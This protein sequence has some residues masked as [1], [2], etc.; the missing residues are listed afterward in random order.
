MIIF[1]LAQCFKKINV[2]NIYPTDSLGN[3][4]GNSPNDNQWKNTEYKSSELDLFN[5]LDTANLSGT[6]LPVISNSY[7]G[8]PNPF[9]NQIRVS[10]FLTQPLNGEIILKYVVANEHMKS[11]Q[12]GCVR[13]YITSSINFTIQGNFK[14]GN[15]RLYFTYS[16]Q[17]H[18]HFFKTWGNI[19]KV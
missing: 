13:L 2:S 12:K 18:E 9:T 7:Y 6:L 10:T 19:K 4:M 5:E 3:L 16:S 15:Y 14:S 11:V 1:F 17:G 8:F